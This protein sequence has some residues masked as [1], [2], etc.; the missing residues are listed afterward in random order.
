MASNLMALGIHNMSAMA[1]FDTRKFAVVFSCASV[2][3]ILVVKSNNCFYIIRKLDCN[4]SV[5]KSRQ[6]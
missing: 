3:A 1:A 2:V 4:A 5:V 6:R